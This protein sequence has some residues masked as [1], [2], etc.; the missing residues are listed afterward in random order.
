[1]CICTL[2]NLKSF[3]NTTLKKLE[4]IENLAFNYLVPDVVFYL[5]SNLSNSN[6]YL[7]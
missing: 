1:M 5:G 2:N 6:K 4:S 3:K 7:Q